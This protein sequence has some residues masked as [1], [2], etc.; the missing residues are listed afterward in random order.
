MEQIKLFLSNRI[1]LTGLIAF[2]SAQ[3][4]KTIIYLIINKEL[5]LERIFG[6]GGMPSGHTATV[7]SVAAATGLNC[8]FDSPVFAVAFILAVIVMHDARGVR[9]E[10]GKQARIINDI[11]ETFRNQGNKN[12]PPGD[13]L[14][15]FVGHTPLQVI[16]GAI[17]GITVAIIVHFI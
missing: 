1:L 13:Q 17:L 5:R 6:D 10:T 16:V 15:E 8:G 12:I 4:L 3:I 14:K 7:T 9:Q 2:A 11:L